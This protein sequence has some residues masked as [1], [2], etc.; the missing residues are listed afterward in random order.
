MSHDIIRDGDTVIIKMHDESGA[1]L[2]VTSTGDQ[3]IG[4]SKINVKPLIGAPFGSIFEIEGRKIRRVVEEKLF[5]MTIEES[6]SRSGDNRSFTDSNTAQKL[7]DDDIHNLRKAGAT[8]EN[9]IKSLIA[10]SETWNS[11]TEFAQEKWLKRKQKK[12]IRRFRVVKCTPI[13]LCEAYHWKNNNKICNMRWDTL[14]QIMS[15]AGI[16]AG[17]HVVV[18][19]S[20]MG[21][22]VGSIAYR[23]RGLGRIMCLFGGQQPHLDL[24]DRLNLSDSDVSII[25]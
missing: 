21:L 10:N 3:K 13:T 6:E 19:E 18:F 12:Y 14:A 7:T 25:H 16:C 2:Q 11:K 22:M 17:S 20:I 4:K 8:G 9:I 15:L 1:M 24:V 5:E 23:M